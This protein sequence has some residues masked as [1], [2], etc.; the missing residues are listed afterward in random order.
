VKLHG[1]GMLCRYC[2]ECS[3][4]DIPA[5]IKAAPTGDGSILLVWR[6]PLHFN[7]ILTKYTIIM[8]D[9]SHREVAEVRLSVADVQ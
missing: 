6:P 9:M 3:D 4:P 7:G 2:A 8:K 1:N 5:D